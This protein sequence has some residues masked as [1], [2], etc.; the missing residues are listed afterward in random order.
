M[1]KT[2]IWPL[3]LTLCALLS[4]CFFRPV[5]QLY[6]IPHPP[7]DYEALQERLGEV[8]AQGG[9]YAAPLTGEMIQAVQLQDLN[10]DGRQEAIA[11]FRF[12]GG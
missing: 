1:K 7:K 10:G 11:F 9:E 2:R 6:A 5:E 4:G 8:V 3:A 12:P